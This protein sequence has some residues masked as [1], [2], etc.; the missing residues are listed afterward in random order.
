MVKYSLFQSNIRMKAVQFDFLS[1]E[2]ASK[3]YFEEIPP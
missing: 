1:K 2:Y 3:H